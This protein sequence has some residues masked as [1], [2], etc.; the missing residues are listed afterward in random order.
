MDRLTRVLAGLLG[1]AAGLLP[2]RRR[3]WAEAALAESG[4]IPAGARR[5][6][7]LSGGLWLVTQEILI[8]SGLR[9]IAFA[10]GVTAFV[11]FNWTG[12]SSNSALLLNRTWMAGTL[13]ILAVL[14][15]VIRRGFGPVRGGWEARAVRVGGYALIL[16]MIAAKA[17]KD[18]DGSELGQFF[19]MN[20]KLWT[21]QAVL[22]VVIAFYVAG[23]LCLT[24]R[25]VRLTRWGLP[26]VVAL[27]TVTAGVLFWVDPFGASID[28]TNAALKW[29]GLAALV[30]PVVTGVLVT[31]LAGRDPGA[32]A[33]T[34]SGQGML[35]ACGATAAAALILAF[36]TSVTIALFPHRVPLAQEPF[37][38][39]ACPTCARDDIT[40]P[41]ALRA[42]YKHEISVGQA[43]QSPFAFLL[44]APIIAIVLGGIAATAASAG[45]PRADPS[46]A[47]PRPGDD[48]SRATAPG[49]A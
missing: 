27:A 41:V 17:V 40:I 30:L 31:R 12:P 37:T 47:R 26:V 45:L 43:G 39:G 19:A 6:A 14:P 2:G 7:W 3:D 13:L 36:L 44:A 8:R 18:R 38:Q 4:E 22:F 25:D 29:W 33:V 9:M 28:P 1:R 21:M 16:V 49:D 10:A 48:G 23:L 32:T 34:A 5:A 24:S 35:A 20:G 15:L 11:W 42:E 46:G